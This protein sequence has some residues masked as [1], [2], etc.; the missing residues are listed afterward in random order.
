MDIVSDLC[1]DTGQMN[2]EGFGIGTGHDPAAGL[3]GLWTNGP[4]E[5][6]PLVFGLPCRTWACATLRPHPA[7]RTLLP[8][9][10]FILAPNLDPFVRMGLA[11]RF[12]LKREVF[13]NA[14]C[15][16]GSAL[17]CRGRGMMLE[18]PIRCR[19]K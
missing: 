11:D 8:E 18:S 6:Q 10:R 4:E 1:A 19:K 16:I 9:P 15:A 13:L 3:T 5:I 12:N 17:R 14:S 2:V 7:Y